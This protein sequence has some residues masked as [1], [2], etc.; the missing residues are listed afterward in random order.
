MATPSSTRTWAE[1]LPSPGK[2]ET[3]RD[4]AARA[5][6]CSG[7]PGTGRPSQRLWGSRAISAAGPR[8]RSRPRTG[9]LLKIPGSQRH[10]AVGNHGPETR[11]GGG[12][13]DRAALTPR[14]SCT[15][16]RTWGERGPGGG[17]S[18]MDGGPGKAGHLWLQGQEGPVPP[19]APEL[20]DA[21][22]R[23]EVGQVGPVGG[24][25]GRPLHSEPWVPFPQRTQRTL[26][27]SFWCL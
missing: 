23:W 4:L 24:A 5:S 12:R 3:Y 2:P 8:G 21:A 9:T 16:K 10:R 17:V 26:P 1:A 14:L 19:V 20:G 15:D 7:S 6:L 18:S 27:S 13:G 22:P 25:T 11:E